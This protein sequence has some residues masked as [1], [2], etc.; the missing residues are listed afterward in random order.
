MTP[1]PSV[2][3]CLPDCNYLKGE[4]SVLFLY[5]LHSKFVLLKVIFVEP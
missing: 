5:P 4:N 1:E 3:N 2:L